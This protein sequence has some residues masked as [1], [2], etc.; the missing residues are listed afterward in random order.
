MKQSALYWEAILWKCVFILEI[1]SHL[2]FQWHI[3]WIDLI[4]VTGRVGAK[5][6]WRSK[7]TFMRSTTFSAV[8]TAP[9]SVIAKWEPRR[10]ATPHS[11]AW[12]LRL[13]L[14]TATRPCSFHG[15]SVSVSLL[16]SVF[17]SLP[18]VRMILNIILILGVESNI[19]KV[20]PAPRENEKKARS[21]RHVVRC[22][23]E[24]WNQ[25]CFLS[26]HSFL[27]W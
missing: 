15:L 3:R 18:E 14:S 25:S 24:T 7:Q 26:I 13:E 4:I 1:E 12:N 20:V 23:A 9:N 5:R 2:P 17:S 22:F 6:P 19:G 27:Q 11:H 8:V 10:Q 16:L 21:T